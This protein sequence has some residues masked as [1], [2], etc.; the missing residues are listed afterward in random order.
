[1]A[2][3]IGDGKVDT[4]FVIGGTGSDFGLPGSL[5]SGSALPTPPAGVSLRYDPNQLDVKAA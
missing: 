2:G 5:T 3:G 1:M 4:S